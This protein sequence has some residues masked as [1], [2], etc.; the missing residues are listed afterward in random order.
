MIRNIVEEH[1]F[2]V[3]IKEDNLIARLEGHEKDFMRKSLKILG[4]LIIH[5]RQLDMI[6]SN[7][8]SINQQRAKIMKDLKEVVT[9]Q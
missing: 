9:A 4:Y 1:G 2:R 7:S 3:E 6:M 8:D 5:T